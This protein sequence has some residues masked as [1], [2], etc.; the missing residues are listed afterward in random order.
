MSRRVVLIGLAAAVLASVACQRLYVRRAGESTPGF[1]YYLPQPYL[2]V[3]PDTVRV[4]WLPNPKEQ[5]AVDARTGLGTQGLALTLEDGWR[6]T[7]VTSNVDTKVPDV[8]GP[9]T[10]LLAAAGALI[11]KGADVR[12]LESP[13]LPA[14][15]FRLYGFVYDSTGMVTGL[16]LLSE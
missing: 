16:R 10:G 8:I 6:L 2:L 7:S 15:Q 4:V 5:Y 13:D 9:A 3:T 12:S 14:G 1:R 11:P